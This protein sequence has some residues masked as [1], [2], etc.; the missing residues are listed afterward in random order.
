MA[1]KDRGTKPQPSED[2][3]A[4]EEFDEESQESDEFIE[5]E[6]DFAEAEPAATEAEA[7]SA[8]R[9][10]HGRSAEREEAAR[11]SLGSVRGTH[12]RVHI[13]DRLSAVFALVCAAALIGLLA[14]TWVGSQLPAPAEPTLTPLVVPTAAAPAS[15]SASGSIVPSASPVVTASPS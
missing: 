10:A 6:E 1:D 13:D 12:E 4:D 5:P 8:R 2:L 14:F 3:P 11:R 7:P 15:V 9:A